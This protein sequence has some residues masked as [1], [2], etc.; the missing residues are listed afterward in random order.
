MRGYCTEHQLHSATVHIKAAALLWLPPILPLH[1]S[2]QVHALTSSGSMSLNSMFRPVQTIR[3]PFAG[4]SRSVS[5]NCQ[6]CREPRRWYGRQSCFALPAVTNNQTQMSRVGYGHQSRHPEPAFHALPSSLSG[7]TQASSYN[8]Q[9]SL[10]GRKPAEVQL[11]A[12]RTKCVGIRRGSVAKEDSPL[13]LFWYSTGDFPKDD[14]W[15]V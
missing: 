11:K 3:C 12:I 2:V 14:D 1:I 10:S 6:S 4:L 7:T 9:G 15:Q 5:K 8:K 13:L